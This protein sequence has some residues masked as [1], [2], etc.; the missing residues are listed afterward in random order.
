MLLC[1]YICARSSGK[2]WQFFVQV[3]ACAHAVFHAAVHVAHDL[4]K[5]Q[6][7]EYLVCPPI[8]GVEDRALVGGQGV[9]LSVFEL[10][11]ARGKD[12]GK[13]H[14][15]DIVGTDGCCGEG[16]DCDAVHEQRLEHLESQLRVTWRFHAVAVEFNFSLLSRAK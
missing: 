11:D 12:T 4:L 9:P 15:E 5:L 7:H 3:V 8:R 14:V 13:E 10:E 16:Y 6:T 1:C 2:P